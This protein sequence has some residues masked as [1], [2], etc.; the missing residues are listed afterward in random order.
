M[1]DNG[2]GKIRKSKLAE[3][4]TAKKDD[5]YNAAYELFTNKGIHNTVIDEIVKKAG[6]AKGTFYL[7]FKDKYDILDMIIIKKSSTVLKEAIKATQEEMSNKTHDLDDV[8]IFFIDYLIE[9][10]R[11][12]KSLL[13]LIYKNLP[14]GIYRKAIADPGHYKEMKSIMDVFIENYKDE[15]MSTE[16]MEKIL[17]S[18]I[19]LTSSTCYSAIV[20]EEPYTIDEMKPVLFKIIKKILA[21]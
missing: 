15:E 9:Y 4:K 18:I 3:K 10:F 14:W 1:D 11:K 2:H 17:Y 13:K 8:V 19:E 20:L 16:N 6:V 21:K 7:Y 5:L 12:N